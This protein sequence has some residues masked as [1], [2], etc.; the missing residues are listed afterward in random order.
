MCLPKFFYE[1]DDSML[2]TSICF[3]KMMPN[4]MMV[5]ETLAA[6]AETIE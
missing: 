3:S 5:S 2:I 1:T 4:E 6:L